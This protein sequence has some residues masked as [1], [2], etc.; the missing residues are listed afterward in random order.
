MT[1][2]ITYLVVDP[3]LK[4]CGASVFTIAEAEEGIDVDIHWSAVYDLSGEKVNPSME[5]ANDFF[6]E[7]DEMAEE[8]GPVD[9]VIVEY[10]P[11]LNLIGNPTLVRWNSWLEGFFVGR[12]SV[13][14]TVIYS[15]SATVKRYFNISGGNH[16]VNKRLAVRK[17]RFYVPG[18]RTDHEADC[19]LM[20]IH[21]FE[22][23]NKKI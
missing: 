20:G 16:A 3:G 13:D 2:E 14:H 12:L 1:K 21:H 22:K 18:V 9:F 5:K 23:K 7:M 11:P 17:A 19:L 8:Y 15:Y 10:Q 4:N 6:E